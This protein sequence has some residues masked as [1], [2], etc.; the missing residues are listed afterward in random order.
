M[1]TR[2]FYYTKQRVAVKSIF[3]ASV[4]IHFLTNV[5]YR[6]F[7]HDRTK[8]KWYDVFWQ[9]LS[10]SVKGLTSIKVIIICMHLSWYNAPVMAVMSSEYHRLSILLQIECWFKCLCCQQQIHHQLTDSVYGKPQVANSFPR[11]IMRKVYFIY[12]LIFSSQVDHQNSSTFF[13]LL[14][15][16][17]I[18]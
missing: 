17:D 3:Y 7:M 18:F 13:L 8:L 9:K 12:Y 11:Q 1:Q 14:T 6:Q 16:V 15:S 10:I 4:L 2:S 5:F